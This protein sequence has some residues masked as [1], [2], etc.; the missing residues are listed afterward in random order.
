MRKKKTYINYGKSPQYVGSMCIERGGEGEKEREGE[1]NNS[2]KL[3]SEKLNL[4]LNCSIN[5]RG[6]DGNK[7]RS[8][9]EGGVGI[10]F[11]P[12]HP[13]LSPPSPYHVQFAAPFDP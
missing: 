11:A 6:R 10:K 5:S 7:G 4:I 3:A 9:P 12:M 1:G 8:V 13:S 2:I